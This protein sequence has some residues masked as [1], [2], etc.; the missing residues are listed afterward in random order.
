[1]NEHEPWLTAL[2]NEHL[3]GVAN[4]VLGLFN[5]KVADPA[6]PWATWMVSEILVAAF[7]VVLFA[8]LRPKLS[9]DKPGGLQHLFETLY[10]FFKETVNDAGIHHGD[11]F[12]PYFGTIFIFILFMNLIGVIPTFESP[13][14][15]AEVTLALALCTFIYY[16]AAGFKANGPAYL[17][18]LLGPVIF[19]APLMVIIEIIS[20]L[21]R[22]LSLT[23]RLYA[24]MLAGDQVT[25]AFEGVVPILVPVIFM[26]L[27]VFVAFLQAYIFMLLS[28][29]YVAGAVS[30]DH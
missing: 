14:M 26:G 25:S 9:V 5:Y 7:I 13:T 12:I 29:V 11:K 24:N 1:M 15:S 6:H 28:T 2:F 4:S 8:L 27:H 17:K 18:Q 19:L 23:I 3:A 16:N 20:H 21:A 10:A 22:P 30:H